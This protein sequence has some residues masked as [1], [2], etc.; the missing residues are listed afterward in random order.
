MARQIKDSGIEWIGKIPE[1][2][3]RDKVVRVFSL[4]GSG[5]TPK[6]TDEEQYGG[7]INDKEVFMSLRKRLRYYGER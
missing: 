7:A 5:T 4:I 1:S 6:S 2:W 3:K